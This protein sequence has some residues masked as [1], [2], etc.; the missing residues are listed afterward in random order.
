[1]WR[2]HGR[3]GPVVVDIPKDV[4]FGKGRYVGP[5]DIAHKTYRPKT[6]PAGKAIKAAVDLIMKAKRPLFYTG[7][8]V[9]NSG[10][11]ASELLV[12]P[13]AR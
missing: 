8:G 9:I 12:M 6:V 7:G 13:G 10:L 4:Q 3:P 5:K 2:P 1:M 11:R